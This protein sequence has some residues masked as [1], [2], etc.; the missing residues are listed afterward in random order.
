MV[1]L[2]SNLGLMRARQFLI[3]SYQQKSNSNNSFFEAV[4][5][6]VYRR[7]TVKTGGTTFTTSRVDSNIDAGLFFL[8]GRYR[9]MKI[10]ETLNIGKTKFPMRGSLPK[11]ELERENIWF[12][13][14]VYEQRQKLNEGKPTF[15]LHD[16]PPYANGNIH[17]GHAMNK[18]SKDIIVRYKSM[19]GFRAPYVPGWDTHG[20]PIEQ[21]LTKAGHDRK[22]MSKAEW[23]KLA[24]KFALEQI[25]TQRADFKRLGVSGDWDHPYIT[26]L[27]K[28]EAAQVRVFGAMAGKGY[29]F[30]GGKPV[31][32]SWSSESALAEAEIEYHDITSKTAFYGNVVVDGRGVLEPGTQLVVW[33]TTP[34]TVPGSRAITVGADFD[35]AVVVV[36][37][38]KYV[39]AEQLLSNLAESFGWQNYTIEKTVKGSEIERV[40]AAHPFIDGLE[41]LVLNGAHVTLD[42]GTGLV[43]TAPDFGEDD[44]FVS[45]EYGIEPNTNLV[46]DQGK[47]TEEAGAAFDGVFY[48]DADDVTLR[49]L[50]EKNLLLKQVDVNHSYPFDWRT[51]QPIIWRAV[52]QWF[53]SIDG[54]RD[55]ILKAIDQDINFLPEWGKKR[56]YNMIRDRG[57]W[58]ISRQRVWGLPLPIF[59][60]EDGT[61]IVDEAVIRHVADLFEEHGSTYWFE[62]EAKELLPEGY[63]N[64]H[65]PNGIFT[66][67]EDIMD[68]WFDSG[69]SWNGVLN[70]REDLTYPADLYLEGSDQYRG[71]FNSSL[72]TSV[73]VNGHAP[74]KNVLSQGFVLDGN[75]EK[76][77]KSLGNIIAPADVVKEMGAEIIRLWV[78]SVDS[79]QDVRVSMDL[80]KQTSETYRKIRNTMRFLLANTADFNPNE[81]AV[82]Y[83]DL[84][85]VDQYFYAKF[86]KLVAQVKTS[87]D[88]FD[89]MRVYKSVVNFI[90]VD[91]SAFY[92]DF[93]KD[94]LYVEAPKGALRRSAQTVLYKVLR[95]LDKL[96]LPILPHTAEEIFEYMPYETADFAY[97]TD[98]PEVE[99]LAN[100]DELITNWTKFMAVRDAVNKALEAARGHELI[101]KPA[102]AA[103]TLYLTDEQRA[104]IDV[105]GQDVRVT[106]L[107]S[108]L[109]LATVNDAGAEVPNF[110]GFKILVEHATGEV[111]PRDRMFH[112][113]LGADA[114]FPM[115]SAHEAQIIR[116]N[117]PE[118]VTEG[119]EV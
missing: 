93:N 26:L 42:S 56:L 105:L 46:D 54:F 35:Y 60:A 21:Q 53:A 18:I 76:M 20:L 16:G 15:M 70:T 14:K 65:S 2:Y 30:R 47:L 22:K 24:E 36:D 95:D 45:K 34:W 69:S 113:D 104:L 19:N 78:S 119:F 25:D 7:R 23:R 71:W 94:V 103:V 74:Y 4:S 88:A 63:T 81:D 58:V 75:G 102:E 50:T 44:Y 3:I 115:L 41:L 51:K 92:L 72:I 28:F 43:H 31:Y 1:I 106:L 117:Y 37:D 85:P 11:T 59:Y 6:T 86:N 9:F 98:M 97:L 55:D 12:E 73:A 29:I 68:V 101:G 80:L 62:H 33:T 112:T 83:A 57:D 109:H 99:E 39:V 87:Y 100:A 108:Q 107:V 8:K 111:S 79:S 40:T 67:E 13:N 90:N 49:L 96:L 116:E 10:K 17:L 77:S 114:D 52:P 82:A 64:E 48:Q 110:D 66:K 91:L 61:E 84:T 32:W 118:A 5:G 89:F 27:P 38:V